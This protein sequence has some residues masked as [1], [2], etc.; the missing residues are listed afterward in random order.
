MWRPAKEKPKWPIPALSPSCE[1]SADRKGVPV[2][3][4]R[5]VVLRLELGPPGRIQGECA[6]HRCGAAGAV[7][8]THFL[9]VLPSV[10]ASPNP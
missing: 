9:T 10:G 8:D 6:R 5:Q 1:S 2:V 4:L 7:I 3:S